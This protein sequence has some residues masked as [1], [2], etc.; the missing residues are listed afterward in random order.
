[1]KTNDGFYV[2]FS[3]VYGSGMASSSHGGLDSFNDFSSFVSYYIENQIPERKS[4][5]EELGGN[6]DFKEIKEDREKRYQKDMEKL[7]N[8]VK[9]DNPTKE[10]ERNAISVI[11]KWMSDDNT[12][13]SV[14]A[15]GDLKTII[16]S[17]FAQEKL[18]ED[19]NH[20]ELLELITKGKFDQNNEEHC[21]LAE[22][23]FDIFQED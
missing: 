15:Y 5:S 17:D 10:D 18:E 14:Q 7:K 13:F 19:G 1:M 22:D 16:E 2:L 23:A 6:E 9:I 11:C 4:C 21:K 20:E 12:N 8:L 3:D